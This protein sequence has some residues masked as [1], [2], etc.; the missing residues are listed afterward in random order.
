MGEVDANNPAPNVAGMLSM[1]LNFAGRLREFE[2]IPA[3]KPAGTAG[4]PFDE[5]ALFNATGYDAKTFTETAPEVVPMVAYDVRKAWVGPAPG[6]PD[7]QVRVEAASLAGKIAAVKVV[8]PWTKANREAPKIASGATLVG[9]LISMGLA[10]V[11]VVFGLIFAVRNLRK[12]R[13]DRKGALRLA[14]VS[15][16]LGLVS[17]I[18]SAHPVATPAEW[19]LLLNALGDIMS[20]GIVLWLLYL[21]LEPAVRSRW[22][23]A[24]VTWNRLLAGQF[25]DAQVGA[26]ILTGA[27]IG[28][29]LYLVLASLNWVDYQRDGVPFGNNLDGAETALSWIGA[30]A[31]RL[32]MDLQSGFMV[33]FT[34]FGFRALWKRDYAAALSMAALF[35][36]IG[37]NGI[38]NDQNPHLLLERLV[39]L[40]IF[41]VLALILI[42]LGM[43]ST[44]A[45]LF[46][47]NTMDRINLGPGLKSWYTP[48]G[49]ATMALLVGIS[50]YAFWR[51]IGA[52]TIGDV[53]SEGQP[54]LSP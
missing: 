53:E 6:L 41:T 39:L 44:V 19:N 33:F 12:N 18:G 5:T 20:T 50:V 43:V 7:V 47:I 3:E 32:Q 52:R 36:V 51:S 22:P 4:A 48:Y 34:I 45:A 28:L 24:L 10:I 17:W 1:R 21:A 30:T 49:L 27:A 38:W 8:F 2:T 11:A 15:G 14:F 25:G 37:N 54:L 29:L 31:K 42:R 40:T 46:F 9:P 16:A 23:Q 13:A 35:A 26:H